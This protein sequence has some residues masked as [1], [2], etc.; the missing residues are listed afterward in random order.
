MIAINL[1]SSR[2]SSRPIWIY[3][4]TF[5]L[6]VLLVGSLSRAELFI[7][8]G[9][10][11]KPGEHPAVVSIKMSE[12]ATSGAEGWDGTC[13]GFLV[14]PQLILTAAHC[15]QGRTQ[16]DSITNAP[17][18]SSGKSGSKFRESELGSHPDFVNPT[19]ESTSAQKIAAAITDIGFIV[20]K[21]P[22]PASEITPLLVFPTSDSQTMS[23]LIKLEATLVGYGATKWEASGNYEH[24]RVGV[25]NIGH[26]P[27]TQVNFGYVVLE[28]PTGACLPGD[29]GG[30]IL[31]EL[32]G[33]T[34]VAALNHG[35]TKS[36]KTVIRTDRNGKPKLDKDGNP[37]T[38]EVPAYGATVGTM[39]TVKNLCWV[40]KT[41]KID[42]A[43]VDCDAKD[44]G[45]GK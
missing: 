6:L 2:T 17:N 27:I 22:V 41:A 45:A 39:L 31:V 36:S 28:G 21:D 29:S 14:H 3:S 34:K 15:L 11:A 40:E 12:R 37:K 32:D 26:K 18:T 20:L 30:P 4:A 7:I 43:G 10:E 38:D 13:T 23:K 44:S 5:L 1:K 16:V 9:V 25:K 35:M 33:S 42:I 19:K 24:S 8:D